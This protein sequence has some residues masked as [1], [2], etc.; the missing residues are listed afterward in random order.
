MG[1]TA[2]TTTVAYV[3]DA[4]DRIVSRTEG[5]VIVRYGYN[6][7]GDSS[8]FTT[9]SL[10]LLVGDRTV[11]LVGGVMATKRLTG[12]VWNYP[13]IH[14]DFVATADPAGAKR[15]STI[16]Y[17]PYG[18]ALSPADPFK[19]DGV[20]DNSAGNYDYGWLG[21]HQRGLEHAP[22][23][24]TIEMGAR[25]YVPSLG[26]FLEVD[27]VE[28]GSCTDYDYVCGDPV[29]NRDLEG[30]HC[31]PWHPHHCVSAVVDFFQGGESQHEAP[32]LDDSVLASD[33][34]SSDAA[35]CAKGGRQNK[36]L[37][38]DQPGK[39]DTPEQQK[40]KGTRRSSGGDGRGT[41][42]KKPKQDKDAVIAPCGPT[43]CEV[44]PLWELHY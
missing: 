42:Q 5:G 30:T 11:G 3:R 27:P 29:N 8:S 17:D 43:I 22:G 13:N 12:D 1:T 31:R 39:E 14:G 25:P 20:P 28:G 33:P 41:Q 2:G 32:S 7:P 10:N 34:C 37:T 40:R 4:T 38:G 18:K 16:T 19:P 35:L 36:R 6:G 15:G 26:R 9:D 24:A 21:Q 44:R 23:L